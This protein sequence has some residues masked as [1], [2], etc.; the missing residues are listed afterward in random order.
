MIFK[1][2]VTFLAF[3]EG[4]ECLKSLVAKNS[5]GGD[6]MSHWTTA[7]ISLKHVNVDILKKALEKIANELG[8][9]VLENF[10]VEGFNASQRCMFG[11]PIDLPYGNGFGI[12]IDN[13]DIVIVGD[14]HGAPISIDELKKKVLRYYL[15]IA[16]AV[17][18]QRIG[19]SVEE[20]REAEKAT[21]IIL[22]R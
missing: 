16:V 2:F 11:L 20:Y 14:E 5:D 3:S 9:R 21:E 22:S 7:R 17:A 15:T 19:F 10:V 6:G 4:R 1:D 13:N 12:S 8:T 18:A